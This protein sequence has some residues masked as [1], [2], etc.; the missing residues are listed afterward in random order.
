[1]DIL[2]LIKQLERY[3]I[4]I[5]TYSNSKNKYKKGINNVLYPLLL[6]VFIDNNKTVAISNVHQLLDIPDTV[7]I[8][9]LAQDCIDR[10]NEIIAMAK[11]NKI[12]LNTSLVFSIRENGSVVFENE[13]KNNDKACFTHPITKR[14]KKVSGFILKYGQNPL[15]LNELRYIPVEGYYE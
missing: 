13:V 10:S 5:P 8:R 9:R 2:T 4:K 12:I 6:R 3:T 14:S 11:C 15:P 1:M 7:Y